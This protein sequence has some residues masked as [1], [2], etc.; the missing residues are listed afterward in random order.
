MLLGVGFIILLSIFAFI[1]RRRIQRENLAYIN[2]VQ[3]NGGPFGPAIVVPV[4]QGGPGQVPQYPAQAYVLQG[5][6]APV[7]S[8]YLLIEVFL[9][10]NITLNSLLDLLQ[11]EVPIISQTNLWPE[12]SNRTCRR[13]TIIPFFSRLS[14]LVS[15][16][17]FCV[18]SLM[19]RKFLYLDLAFIWRV[20]VYCNIKCQ[21][22]SCFHSLC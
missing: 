16:S 15:S 5:V 22:L 1:R 17:L 20:H 3:N 21:T 13:C 12:I 11:P 6:Y 8:L 10:M 19:C 14:F 7:R 4:Y 18:A 2:A 9:K